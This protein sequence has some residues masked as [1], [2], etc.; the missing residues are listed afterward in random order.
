MFK[1]DKGYVDV[2]IDAES[3]TDSYL[4]SIQK[5]LIKLLPPDS[6][7]IIV[8]FNSK[9]DI[10]YRDMKFPEFMKVDSWKEFLTY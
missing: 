4:H 8:N 1:S 7:N 9:Q 6:A 2:Y 5:A 3:F 10:V